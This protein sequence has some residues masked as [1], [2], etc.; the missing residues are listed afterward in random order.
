MRHLEF[1]VYYDKEYGRIKDDNDVIVVDY[2]VYGEDDEIDQ[3][4]NHLTA[5]INQGLQYYATKADLAIANATISALEGKLA[6]AEALLRRSRAAFVVLSDTL[7]PRK[8]GNLA[9]EQ[10]AAID[11]WQKENT[12]E[13]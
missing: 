7:E 10:I 8:G 4:A 11:E 3:F 5:I 6:A 9:R 13:S 2:N 12:D 1:P